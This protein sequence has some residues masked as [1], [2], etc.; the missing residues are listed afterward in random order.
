[1]KSGTAQQRAAVL[2]VGQFF[3]A[4][5]RAVHVV[6][7]QIRGAIERAGFAHQLR[8]LV[9]THAQE[10]ALF[11]HLR[12]QPPA[13]AKLMPVAIAI[14]RARAILQRKNQRQR[15]FAFLQIAQHRLAQLFG[16]RREI[17]QIVHQLKRQPR[18]AP[19]FG[20]RFFDML[21]LLAQHRAEPRASAEEARRLAIGE[22]GRFRLGQIDAPQARRA[23]AVRLR[24]CFA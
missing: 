13:F 18:I 4:G 6:A 7:R 2:R 10:S 14:G 5:L 3:E 11:Q 22:F 24:P 12:H 1:M 16:R 8:N 9:R 23:A 21:R 20:E 19:V 15:H 17:Q